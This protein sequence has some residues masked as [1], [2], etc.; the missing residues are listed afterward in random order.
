MENKTPIRKKAIE[1]RNKLLVTTVEVITEKGYHNTTVDDIAKACGVSTGSAYRYFQ[2]KKEMMIAAME[3][4]FEHIQS[5]SGTEDNI[6]ME[7]HSL[8]DMLSF[9]LEQFYLLHKRYER[10]H[11]ELESLKH[12]DKDFKA[13]YDE[14]MGKAVEKL[15]QKCPKE[16]VEIPNLRERL[17]IGI[18]ILENF[19]HMQMD[20][21]VCKELD[22][23]CIKRLSI[24]SAMALISK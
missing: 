12:I 17:Y 16:I 2:N 21:N 7:Y 3:Y 1:T 14:I 6:L 20:E 4:S 18:G 9:A 23:E 8:E 22:M 15:I 11:E 10:L 5:L 24:S 13:V 19:A